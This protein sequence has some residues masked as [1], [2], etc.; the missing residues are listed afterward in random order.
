G[1]GGVYH[2]DGGTATESGGLQDGQSYFVIKV[3]DN[4]IEL[5][6]SK[7]EALQSNPTPITLTS[8]GSGDQSLVTLTPTIDGLA[9]GGAGA[10]AG[11]PGLNVALA[12]AG[13]GVLNGVDNDIEAHIKGCSSTAAPATKGVTAS[14]GSVTL[15]ASDDGFI[16]S[17]VGGFAAAIAIGG[18]SG[19][20]SIGASV[21]DNEIG[22]NSGQSVK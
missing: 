17:D 21:G 15:T 19:A 13:A 3:D 9:M 18:I 6:A 22:Q 2:S 8:T 16:R 20:I 4:T 5:A 11:G 14:H 12:G 10:G 1:D 7:A